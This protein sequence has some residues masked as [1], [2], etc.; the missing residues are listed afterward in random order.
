MSRESKASTGERLDC[1]IVTFFFP[2]ALGGLETYLERLAKA[3]H[4]D[5][6]VAVLAPKCPED[7]AIDRD[8][9]Y[10]VLRRAMGASWIAA[11]PKLYKPLFPLIVLSIF[12]WTLFALRRLRPRVICA[13]SA[14]F[15][16]PVAAAAALLGARSCFICHGKDG[17]VRPGWKAKILKRWPLVFAMRSA[18][19]IFPNSKFTMGLLDPGGEFRDKMHILYPP[20]TPAKKGPDRQKAIERARQLIRDQSAGAV[21]PNHV[22]IVLSVGRLIERKGFQ[23]VIDAMG[24]IRDEIPGVVYVI[25]GGGPYENHLRERAW[26][27]G[28]GRRVVFV[29][30]QRDADAFYAIASLFITVSWELPGDVEGFGMTFVEAG[31]FG[32]PSIAGL[33]GGM[34]EAAPHEET[35]LLVE[36]ANPLAIAAAL[37]RL[38]CDAQLRSRLGDAARDFARGFE[39]DRIAREFM[40]QTGLVDD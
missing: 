18:A 26:R 19:W 32:V 31:R 8:L 4:E 34:P 6:W 25:V 38:L 37:R 36:G 13:G 30:P 24:L 29:G 14:D 17:H 20:V 33:S 11:R 40:R 23:H 9:S 7:E 1:V 3:L 35:G 21:D 15:A 10:R 39:P 22:Q 5:I 28:L 12:F 16:A 2:P 27:A